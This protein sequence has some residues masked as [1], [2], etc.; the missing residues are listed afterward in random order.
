MEFQFLGTAAATSVPLVFCNCNICQQARINKGKDIRKRAS[1]IINNEMLI[2]LGPDLCSQAEMYD[3]DLS[4][5]KYLLQ[6]H[7]HSD[8]FEASE[9]TLDQMHTKNLLQYCNKGDIM[10]TTENLPSYS[11]NQLLGDINHF[12]TFITDH[13]IPITFDIT[14][15]AASGLD[16]IDTFD[17]LKDHVQN[18][19]LSN[20]GN[21][22]EHKLLEDGDIDIVK[23]MEYLRKIGYDGLLTIEF[24]F[25]N[26]SR[27]HIIDIQDAEKKLRD[28]YH[29]ISKLI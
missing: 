8:H 4:K 25:E 15:C 18:I 14:H 3:I 27:N 21:G 16:I 6:T 1:A 5:V 10:I 7:S 19:H 20:Y 28:T 11:E 29:F 12:T 23:F 2:D 22:N 17:K 24:D 13:N 26:P 9:L